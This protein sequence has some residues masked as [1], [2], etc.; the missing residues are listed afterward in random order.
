[1]DP[2]ST[3]TRLLGLSMST[4]NKIKVK[5]T[6]RAAPASEIQL[7]LERLHSSSSLFVSSAFARL[8]Q[9]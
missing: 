7:E 3:V 8:V 9:L 4:K 6:A 5:P 2:R 1:M